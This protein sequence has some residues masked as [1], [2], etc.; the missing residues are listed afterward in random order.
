MFE[1]TSYVGLVVF[2]M[3]RVGLPGLPVSVLYSPGV[4]VRMGLPQRLARG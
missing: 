3:H 4:P 1:G 2:R